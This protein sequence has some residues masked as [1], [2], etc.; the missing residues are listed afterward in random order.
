VRRTRFDPLHDA[1]NEQALWNGLAG[2]LAAL[3]DA[4]TT[5]IEIQDAQTTHKVEFSREA[6]L[7]ATRQRYAS[8]LTFVQQHCPA[9]VQ[10]DLVLSMLQP[11]RR[12]DRATRRTAL[13]DRARGGRTAAAALG[14]LRHSNEIRRRP[15]QVALVSRLQ[16]ARSGGGS[17][18]M[19]GAPR[20]A[21]PPTDQPTHL[22]FQGRAREISQTPLTVGWSVPGRRTR[23]AGAGRARCLT[24]ALHRVAQGRSRLARGSQH[25]RHVR[26]RQPGARRG[27]AARPATRSGSAARA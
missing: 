6:L 5:E 7:A 21:I 11:Q 15:G 22:L 3:G 20:L 8:L 12:G 10:T 24:C 9:G 25:V 19:D 16:I 4:E 17:A 27:G 18:V 14:A 26:E 2:W 23:A 13:G 1:R